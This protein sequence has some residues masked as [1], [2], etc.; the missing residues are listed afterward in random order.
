MDSQQVSQID[1]K[2]SDTRPRTRSWTRQPTGNVQRLQP[3][4]PARGYFHLV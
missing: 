2:G 1:I 3:R 4:S